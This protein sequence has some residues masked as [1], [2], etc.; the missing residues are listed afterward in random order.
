MSKKYGTIGWIG[1]LL[2]A[3]AGCAGQQTTATANSQSPGSAKAVPGSTPTQGPT[4]VITKGS[5]GREIGEMK[6][7]PAPDSK[8]AKLK[9]GMSQQDVMNTIGAPNDSQTHETGKRW[10]PF[11]FGPDARRMETLYKGE[12]CL[13]FTG[14]NIYGSG[15][16][17]L[18]VI[19]VDPK[20]A[21]FN[22]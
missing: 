18:I 14:G 5:D 10:I 20:G 2:M 11:Y 7:K 3:M 6:G 9:F 19:E 4:T 21:C 1:A 13:T 17:E 15:A 8:F 12:G 16:S 22:S